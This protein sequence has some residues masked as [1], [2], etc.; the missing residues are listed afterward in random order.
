MSVYPSFHLAIVMTGLFCIGALDSSS[1][2]SSIPPMRTP[3]GP[4]TP[5]SLPPIS[6]P[7]PPPSPSLPSFQSMTH[8]LP[9]PNVSLNTCILYT[10]ETRVKMSDGPVNL[11]TYSATGILRELS[12][13][14]NLSRWL[15]TALRWRGWVCCG[16]S[17]TITI[18]AAGKRVGRCRRR[19]SKV[20]KYI[21]LHRRNAS[22]M[23]TLPKPHWWQQTNRRT[24][25]QWEKII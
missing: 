20:I 1:M 18:A 7:H 12:E 22:Q 24:A 11:L 19:C 5:P 10:K 13:Q 9:S 25:P 8:P 21:A 2:D 6:T 14:K 15:F 16:S 4:I 3:R 17:I 23:Q